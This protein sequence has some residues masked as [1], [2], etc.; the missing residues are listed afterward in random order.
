MCGA[1][2]SESD[3]S[4]TL[5]MKAAVRDGTV[6][7]E[8]AHTYMTGD[9]LTRHDRQNHSLSAVLGSHVTLESTLMDED[10]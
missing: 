7:L 6:C 9:G 3:F 2:P 4:D 10:N 1:V 8:L 5:L